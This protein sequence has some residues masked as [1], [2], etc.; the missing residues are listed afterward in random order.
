MV[1]GGVEVVEQGVGLVAGVD[2][3]GVGVVER[4]GGV[5]AAVVVVLGGVGAAQGP[6]QV[7]EDL[8]QAADELGEVPDGAV[9]L[10]PSRGPRIVEWLAARMA[11]RRVRCRGRRGWSSPV[12][13]V[14]GGGA[15]GGVA[16]LVGELGGAAGD[17]GA[18]GGEGGEEQADGD[19]A[20]QRRRGRPC[21]S[22][23][24]GP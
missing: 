23:R 2:E 8:R 17:G 6:G 11:R 10:W 3:V 15:V 21:G 12:L 5:A 18:E 1:V 24:A 14:D 4:G 13:L 9:G 22:W 19:D 20:G 7:V 16:E